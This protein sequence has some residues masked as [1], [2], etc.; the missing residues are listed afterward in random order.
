MLSIELIQE[1]HRLLGEGQLSQ[2]QIAARLDV[3]RGTVGAIASGR[4]GL[5]GKGGEGGALPAHTARCRPARCRH[6]GYRVYAPCRICL[7]RDYRRQQLSGIEP[8]LN[9]T[10]KRRD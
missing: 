9:G 5:K 8:A 6:C 4:R 2:R 1:I 7:A 10:R 3:S